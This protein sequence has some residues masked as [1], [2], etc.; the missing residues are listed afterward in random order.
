MGLG[1]ACDLALDMIDAVDQLSEDLGARLDIRIGVHTGPAVGG[2]I[3]SRKFAFDLWG[4]TVNLASRLESSGVV[5]DVQVSAAV[6][7][8]VGGRYRI[9]ANGTKDLKGEGPTPVFL[10]RR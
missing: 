9:E 7:R 2:V 4:D 3:G 10:L 8:A 1:A 6:Q 5:G